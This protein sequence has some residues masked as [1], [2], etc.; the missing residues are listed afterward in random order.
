MTSQSDSSRRGIV[1]VILRGERFLVIRRSQHVRAPLAHCF[2][3]GAIE[4]G[5]D[6]PAAASR[7]VREE[8][9]VEATPLRLLWRSTTPWGVALA[10]WLAEIDAA[11]VPV[12]NPQEVESFA[13]L[14]AAEIRELPGLL[15]SN[16]EFLAAVERGEISVATSRESGG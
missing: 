6:E 10:W 15:E 5:E 2:P 4:P 11:C 9:A 7:E 12:P 14:T 1:A 3:G 8:L 16:L 13:W